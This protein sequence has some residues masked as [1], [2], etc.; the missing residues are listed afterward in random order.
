MKKE[1]QPALFCPLE[2]TGPSMS[3]VFNKHTLILHCTF[4]TGM[5]LPPRGR[6]QVLMR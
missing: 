1:L 4:S 5:I 2:T 3:W 6:K